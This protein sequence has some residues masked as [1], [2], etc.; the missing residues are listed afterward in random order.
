MQ[1]SRFNKSSYNN[2]NNYRNNKSWLYWQLWSYHTEFLMS[3][4]KAHKLSKTEIFPFVYL[5][6]S[7]SLSSRVPRW[8]VRENISKPPSPR[9]S[10]CVKRAFKG[11]LTGTD[12][13][14]PKAHHLRRPP[15]SLCL[16]RDFCEGGTGVP[17]FPAAG[18]GSVLAVLGLPMETHSRVGKTKVGERPWPLNTPCLWKQTSSASKTQ[19]FF[20]DPQTS[21]FQTTL[22]FALCSPTLLIQTSMTS[23]TTSS[24]WTWSHSYAADQK[25]HSWWWPMAS[26]PTSSP[27][28]PLFINTVPFAFY[29]LQ[30]PHVLSFEHYFSNWETSS[31]LVNSLAE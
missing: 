29:E 8:W 7:E 3:N 5:N 1:S 25:N 10:V 27:P 19:S 14:F 15:R 18:H 30:G 20:A 9:S 31:T 16:N 2:N 24:T 26:H 21:H 6:P 17:P 23:M 4:F 12:D 13:L 28:F 22:W 11:R